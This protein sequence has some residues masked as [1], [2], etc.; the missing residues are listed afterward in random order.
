MPDTKPPIDFRFAIFRNE[1]AHAEAGIPMMHH[2]PMTDT[3]IAG[4]TKL[5]EA[6]ANNG[7]V[8][9]LL[10]ST[11]K[12]SLAHAWFKSGF[13]LP[14]HSHDTDCL[15]YV[16]AGSL[17][18][19]TSELKAGDGFFVGGGV[20]YTYTPGPE[21]VEVLEF[22]ADGDFNIKLLANNPAF[23][24]RSLATVIAKQASWPDETPPTR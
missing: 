20:P 9:R 5:V 6:G 2:E 15:Y 4:G 8:T 10:F 11:G 12:F 3:E 1:D 14:R 17:Q 19:G 21:G 22:R 18:M 16:V 23:W 7:H 24:E 13:P